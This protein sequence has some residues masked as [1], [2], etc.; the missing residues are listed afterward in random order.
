[1][2]K[3]YGTIKKIMPTETLSGGFTKRLF[4]LDDEED[5]YPN[6][7]QFELW[8]D[9]VNMIDSYEV[10]DVVTCFIDLKGKHWKRD[11]KEGVMNSLKCWNIEKNGKSYKKLG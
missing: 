1:M 6:T 2:I 7:F 8:K 10:G 5:K 3:I 4:W 9:D 11:D